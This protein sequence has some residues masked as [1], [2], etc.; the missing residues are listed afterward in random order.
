MSDLVETNEKGVVWSNR[1]KYEY[2]NAS[3]W[4]A[5]V[6]DGSMRTHFEFSYHNQE[7]FSA[8]GTP[9]GAVFRN[10]LEE[11]EKIARRKPNLAFELRRREIE[12]QEYSDMLKMAS[13]ELANTMVVISDFPEELADAQEDV[14]GFNVSRKQTMLRVISRQPDGK[15]AIT[16]QSLDRSERFALEAIYEDFGFIPAAGELL[17]QRIYLDCD[18]EDQR[19]LIDRLMGIYDRALSARYGGQWQAGRKRQT[20][21][22]TYEF[23][24]QQHDLI[25]LFVNTRLESVVRAEHM[26]Y[27]LAAAIKERYDKSNQTLSALFYEQDISAAVYRATHDASLLNELVLAG[28]AAYNRGNV[29]SGC[30][31]SAIVNNLSQAEEQL[32]QLGFGNKTNETTTYKFDKK[33]YCVVCQ[34]PPKKGERPKL[35]GPCSICRTCDAKLAGN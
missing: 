20:A 6:L 12:Q 4:L 2:D 11:A 25:D 17:A 18:E 33:A 8:D 26:R 34:K 35:C 29:F 28:R 27:N 1:Y 23:V 16:T 13:G 31:L 30:G 7:L 3:T 24:L 14:L 9:L 10:S 22:N 32:A 15:I 5:E 19:Y 21:N